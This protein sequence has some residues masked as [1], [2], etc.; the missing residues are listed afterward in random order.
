LP[1]L[2]QK[3]AVS[4]HYSATLFH[5]SLHQKKAE[6]LKANKSF[7]GFAPIYA[8]ASAITD[9]AHS[10]NSSRI[11]S[12]KQYT[13]ETTRSVTLHGKKYC[14]LIYSEKEVQQVAKIFEKHGHPSQTLFHDEASKKHFFQQIKEYQY[15]LV[16]A[17]G[18]RNDKQPELSGIIFSPTIEN[19]EEDNSVMYLSD[20][21]HLQLNAD[22]VVLSCCESG[23]GELAKGEGMMAMNRG[24]LY[25][26]AKNI[27]FT[28]FKVYD[29]A[30]SK[31]TQALFEGIVGQNLTY[32]EAL[33]RAK[34][35]LIQQKGFTPKAWAGYVL[36]GS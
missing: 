22:L 21:Y 1:Y 25:A 35:E 11:P 3:F 32:P 10:P 14:E 17:H 8:D 36:I 31:L 26:G 5:H 2:I 18:I 12:T 16:A 6:S 28:L 27:L 19:S 4:Y 30:S 20:A 15:V 29:K 34:L 9:A 24:F 13:A 7:I 23:V 33:Q